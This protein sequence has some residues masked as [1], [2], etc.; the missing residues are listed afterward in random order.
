MDR[1]KHYINDLTGDRFGCAKYSSL[2]R[3]ANEMNTNLN[4]WREVSDE[5]LF[6]MI[7]SPSIS[8][9]SAKSVRD[10]AISANLTALD[11]EWQVLND[12]E[13]IRKV[14][15]DAEIIGAGETE[16]EIF[17]L[18]DNT[19]RETTLAELRQVLAAH[20]A[21]KRGIWAQFGA[22]DNGPKT[23]PFVIE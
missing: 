16:T 8:A 10:T 3:Y 13:D 2:E 11:C 9:L 15:G 5:E 14:I 19:W 1:V 6:I 20:V 17:R 21:R 18:A 22:W 23:E 7:N 12:A 4:D